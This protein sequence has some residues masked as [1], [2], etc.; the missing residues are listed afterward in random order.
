MSFRLICLRNGTAAT[1]EI[2]RPPPHSVRRQSNHPARR[3]SGR[4]RMKRVLLFLIF[5]SLGFA[6][7]A[8]ATCVQ[9]SP[10]EIVTLTGQGYA[11]AAVTSVNVNFGQSQVQIDPDLPVNSVI[12][13]G[14]STP[15][16]VQTNI[17]NCLNGGTVALSYSGATTSSVPGVYQTNVPGIGFTLSYVRTGGADTSA[18]P[19]TASF[20]AGDP[21]QIIYGRFGAGAYFQI[22]LI[23]TGDIAS[24]VFVAFGTVGQAQA[25]D[26][27][28]VATI[29]A[30]SI[31]VKVLPNCSVDASTLN[32]DFGQFGPADVSTTS[33]P[34]QPVDFTLLCSGPTPPASITATLSGTPDTNNAGLLR[35]T[36]AQNLAIR[37]K[38]TSTGIVLRPNDPTSTLVHLP[39]GGMQSPFAID[40]TVLRVGAATPTAGKIQ[41]TATIMLSIL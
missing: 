6:R 21:G 24:N 1:T 40:A 20:T 41:A 7:V 4:H 35:N 36:G 26:G 2:V 32:I 23:K 37:L 19:W 29:G 31:N 3:F 25:Q 13:T 11:A 15:F 12:A 16:G 34:T 27:K 17:A 8:S 14:T 28:T 39:A 33:G 22:Q 18:F 10:A 9:L 30:G 38:E 5:A